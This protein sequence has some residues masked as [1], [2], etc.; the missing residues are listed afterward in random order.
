MEAAAPAYRLLRAQMVAC[1]ALPMSLRL[2]CGVLRFDAQGGSALP[3][4]K[5]AAIHAANSVC[6]WRPSFA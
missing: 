5:R 2:L 3:Q 4:G 6:L 1:I